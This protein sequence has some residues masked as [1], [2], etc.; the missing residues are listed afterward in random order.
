MSRKQNVWAD[1]L[2]QATVPVVGAGLLMCA[3]G[4]GLTPP[5]VAVVSIVLMDVIFTRLSDCMV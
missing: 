4:F 3:A 1:T 2:D 5:I